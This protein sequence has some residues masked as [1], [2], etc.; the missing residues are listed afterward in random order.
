MLRFDKVFLYLTLLFKFILSET[1]S[2]S[3]CGLEILLFSEFTNIV[4]FLYYNC[5]ELIMLLYTF[6]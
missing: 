3:L 5:I 6:W 4:Y 1:L 2:K